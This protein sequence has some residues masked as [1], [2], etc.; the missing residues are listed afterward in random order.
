MT[1][2]ELPIKQIILSRLLIALEVLI[3]FISSCAHSKGGNIFMT[4]VLATHLGYETY[5]FL[6]YL[7]RTP[8]HSRSNMSQILTDSWL[9][10]RPLHNS[11]VDE[12]GLPVHQPQPRRA[13][14]FHSSQTRSNYSQP[15]RQQQPQFSRPPATSQEVTES[16]E[17]FGTAVAY[18]PPTVDL[19]DIEE[20]EG[21]R[22]VSNPPDTVYAV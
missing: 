10:D 16:E 15:T 6:S 20:D 3:L 5:K 18:I 14:P 19:D 13:D 8:E 12:H 17:L 2:V 4:L 9:E 11:G 7:Q 22:F 21:S 1:G